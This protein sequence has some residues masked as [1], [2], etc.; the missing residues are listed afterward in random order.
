[1]RFNFRLKPVVSVEILQNN[2]EI[3]SARGWPKVEC[4]DR[5][6]LAVVGGGH[7]LLSTIDEL[8]HWPGEVWACG[9]VHPWLKEN[10]VA[11]VFFN[12]DPMAEMGPMAS[13]SGLLAITSDPSVFEAVSEAETFDLNDYGHGNTTASISAHLAL[14]RG[15]REVTYFGCDSSFETSTHL[16]KHEDWEAHLLVECGGVHFRT[17]PQLLMQAEMLSAFIRMAPQVFTERSGGLLRAMVGCEAYDAQSG[18]Q[19]MH[20]LLRGVS[21]QAEYERRHA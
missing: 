7:S 13:G 19:A 6:P 16:Y 9:S 20:D 4:K 15:H 11:S 12:A 2:A 10:G 17:K 21:P 8:R 18:N 14:C 3:N 1:M 5:P